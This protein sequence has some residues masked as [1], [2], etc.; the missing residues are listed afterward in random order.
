MHSSLPNS[1]PPLDILY[2]GPLPPHHGGSAVSAGLILSQIA[3]EGHSIRAIAPLREGACEPQRIFEKSQHRIGIE[4]FTTAIDYTAPNLPPPPGYW[5]AERKQVRSRLQ[6]QIERKRP[7]IV[8]IGRETYAAHSVPVAKAN[9]LPMLLRISGAQAWGVYRGEFP[10]S[11]RDEFC[12]ALKAVS[13]ICP[14]AQHMACIL[15]ALGVD[16]VRVIRNA[17]DLERFQ[18]EPEN[19]ALRTKLRIPAGHVVAVHMSN[20]KAIKRLPDIA[21]SA[22][23]VLRKNNNITYVIIGD[24]PDRSQAEEI[25]RREGVLGHFRFVDWLDYEEIPALLNLAGVVIMPSEMEH[26]ARLYLESQA[27]ERL[28]IASDVA[29]AREVVT[30]GETGLLYRM[31]DIDD[32]AEKTLLAAADPELRARL[33]RAAGVSVRRHDL[34]RVAA[35]YVAAMREIIAP[36]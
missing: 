18:P 4:R 9:G 25:C 24:G 31:G 35:D 2:V 11:F 20:M 22:P 5:E 3:D 23:K 29:G 21:R 26:Q 32:L 34:K 30:D 28:L 16:H 10:E 36:R 1:D 12:A 7:D 17:V 19:A 8:L 14:Q 27:C 6:A 13:L 33:G 15:R